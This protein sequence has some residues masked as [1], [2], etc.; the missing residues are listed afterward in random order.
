MHPTSG[1]DFECVELGDLVKN[2][3][4]KERTP[5]RRIIHFTSG[6]IMEEYSTD[7]E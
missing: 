4:R 1:K 6:Q 5:R 3:E 2:G 7:K